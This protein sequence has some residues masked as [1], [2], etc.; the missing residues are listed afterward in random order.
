MKI[1]AAVAV[2][3]SLVVS[4]FAFA[5]N[6]V[7][8]LNGFQFHSNHWK[9]RGMNAGSLEIDT[10]A[11]TMTLNLSDNHPACEPEKGACLDPATPVK[12]VF[13]IEKTA[14]AQCGMIMIRGK[15]ER[16]IGD[17]DEETLLLNERTLNSQ[18]PKKEGDA[19]VRLQYTTQ[20]WTRGS[21]QE[22]SKFSGY[23]TFPDP[24]LIPLDQ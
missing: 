16:M 13:K 1:Q 3:F 20:G 5:E 21:L 15:K 9:F 17:L 18:C 2:L 23:N 22:I 24:S 19:D 8:V 7:Y 10:Q 14:S 4:P 6:D 12:I 11:Q